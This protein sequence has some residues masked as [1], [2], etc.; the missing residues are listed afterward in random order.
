M[1][2]PFEDLKNHVRNR[3]PWRKI[4]MVTESQD[5]MAFNQPNGTENAEGCLHK[6]T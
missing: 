1:R 2:A 4:Y 5:L 3:S 6:A